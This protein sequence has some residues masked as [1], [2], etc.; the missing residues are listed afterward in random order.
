MH[1]YLPSFNQDQVQAIVDRFAE[2]K[3]D[4]PP[5]EIITDAVTLGARTPYDA[6]EV[7]DLI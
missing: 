5:V 6:D 1:C 2:G 4:E 7:L 3:N